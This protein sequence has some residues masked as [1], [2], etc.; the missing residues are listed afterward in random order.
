M[1]VTTFLL[2]VFVQVALT[3][4]LH[5]LMAKHRLGSIKSGEV[6]MKDIAL[7]EP[8]WTPR[9]LQISN[10]Y[11]N[12]LELP[13]LFYA[14]VAFILITKQE[15]IPLLMLAWI[16]AISRLIHAYI[17][18]TTNYVPHRFRAYGVGAIAVFAMWIVFA[19]KILAGGS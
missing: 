9:G 7:R 15:S 5:V 14:V 8:N 6:R 12:Q 10:A 11:N 1:T 2:P 16:F 3:I 19:V 4:G 13:M 18:I 17:H